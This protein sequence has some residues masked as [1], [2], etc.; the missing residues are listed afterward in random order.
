MEFSKSHCRT[1]TSQKYFMSTTHLH[2]TF[3]KFFL[4]K[5]PCFLRLVF[6]MLVCFEKQSIVANVPI[7]A[8]KHKDAMTRHSC[9]CK[10]LLWERVRLYSVWRQV[11][12]RFWISSLCRVSFK[13]TPAQSVSFSSSL[14]LPLFSLFLSYCL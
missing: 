5:F 12:A 2:V 8:W 10:V 6:S 3:R 7:W 13:S 1:S 14:P 4:S 9:L 11:Q